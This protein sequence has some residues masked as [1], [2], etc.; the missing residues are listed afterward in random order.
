MIWP[1]PL[2]R[3][4]IFFVQFPDHNASAVV[5]DI[6]VGGLTATTFEVNDISSVFRVGSFDDLE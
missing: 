6:M 2:G 4:I 1:L 3:A 5:V